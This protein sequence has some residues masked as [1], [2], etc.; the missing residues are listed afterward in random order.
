M[1][2][3]ARK[4]CNSNFGPW[5]RASGLGNVVKLTDSGLEKPNRLSFHS[6]WS[7][8]DLE[9]LCSCLTYLACWFFTQDELV[10]VG[11]VDCHHNGKLCGTLKVQYGQYYY[12]KL[13]INAESATVSDHQILE[14]PYW[15][16]GGSK[17][18]G[19]MCMGSIDKEIK[20][21][22]CSPHYKM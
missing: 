6:D 3:C 10:H 20:S 2:A 8:L 7:I 15:N 11:T 4:Q 19:V 22:K 21:P 9:D 13:H 5:H 14:P 18:G 17:L 1:Y 12:P 16:H